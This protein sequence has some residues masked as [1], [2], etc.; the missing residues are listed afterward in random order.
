MDFSNFIE[1]MIG[2]PDLYPIYLDDPLAYL[3]KAFKESDVFVCLGIHEDI[4]IELPKIIAKSNG[5]ALLVPCEG[6]DWVS[7]WVREK[8]IDECE[9]YGLAY[10]FPKPFCSMTKGK[11]EILNQFMDTFRI[12]KPKFRLY[13][14][15]ENIIVKAEVIQ[16]APCGNGYNVAKHLIGAQL[17][18]EA[19][20]V[21]AKAWHSFPCMGG[22]TIDPE[23]GDTILHIG[24]YLHYSALENAE[25]FPTNTMNSSSVFKK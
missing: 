4:L 13:V 23:L 8:A 2:L 15:S 20:K 5:K 22:M 21:V 25:I 11:F 16:S 17:G 19:K 14:N 10:D 3:P 6:A 9:K 1:E 24:G 12:G 18:E 7:R